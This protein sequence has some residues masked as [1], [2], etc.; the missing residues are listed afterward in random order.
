M[1]AELQRTDSMN[2]DKD[3]QFR[4]ELSEFVGL[5][6]AVLG[7]T[8][9]G[10][11]NTDAVIAE[12]ALSHGYPL[13][14]VDPEGEFFSLK[15]RFE[16]LVAGRSPNVDIALTSLAQTRSL[17][18]LSMRRG[19]P[20]VLDLSGFKSN[21]QEQEEMFGLV[22]AYL[23][24]LWD[25][26][27]EIRRPY[28]LL[29]E[30]AQEFV[31]QSGSS[32][33]KE[34]MI[35]IAKRGRKRGLGIVLASQRPA[36]VEKNVLTQ[37]RMLIL[38]KVINPNTDLKAYKD[39][40]P[41]PSRE[42]E[43]LVGGLNVGQAIILYNNSY[44]MVQVRRRYTFD[45]GATPGFDT[46][47]LE[48]VQI[49]DSLLA[50][51]V[52]LAE[53]AA[54]NAAASGGDGQTLS[55]K[56]AQ[57]ESRVR[58]LE[59]QLEKAQAECAELRRENEKLSKLSVHL[60]GNLLNT[61]AAATPQVSPKETRQPSSLHIEQATVQELKVASA[62]NTSISSGSDNNPVKSGSLSHSNEVSSKS[63]RAAQPHAKSVVSVP[64]ASSEK[65]QESEKINVKAVTQKRAFK[66]LQ[67][68]L[69]ELPKLERAILQLLLK[70]QHNEFGSEDMAAWLNR[71]EADVRNH[72]PNSLLNLKL[73]KRHKGASG[74]FVYQSNAHEFLIKYYPNLPVADLLEELTTKLQST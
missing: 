7:M 69:A 31:P 49:N 38:H 70:Y 3:N 9:Q 73:V 64:N 37:A 39:L 46:S 32:P 71:S 22:E 5:S 74:R 11:T 4:L 42:V 45:V 51:F 13:T 27:V 65:E 41:L 68:R 35:R 50:E 58:E 30:E 43:R 33:V 24:T 44:E 1:L 26:A 48:K 55:K 18:E 23:E 8:G 2:I 61:M 53:K 54:S 34:L 62:A 16:I 40:I 59:A 10:K 67:A 29:V 14:I 15:E 57:L 52:K 28:L 36:S 60:D 17:A 63:S 56:Q 20:V 66:Q 72:P 47:R 6:V 21:Q 25:L 19:V 12:E